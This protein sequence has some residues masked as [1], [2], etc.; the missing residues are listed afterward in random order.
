M[1]VTFSVFVQGGLL[2]F[3][4]KACRVSFASHRLTPYDVSVRVEREP[5]GLQRYVVGKG[6]RVVGT[7]VR[8]LPIGEGAWLTLVV[9]GGE[10]MQPRG[11]YVLRGGDEVLLLAEPGD[12]PAL[13]RLFEGPEPVS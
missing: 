2:P 1:V 10:A 12:G 6:S 7:A 13:R 3:V 11:S 4:A 5:S 8:D 9:H